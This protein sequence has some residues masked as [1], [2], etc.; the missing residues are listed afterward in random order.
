MKS[1]YRIAELSFGYPHWNVSYEFSMGNSHFSVERFAACFST[2]L[3]IN[4][5][6]A[7]SSAV[8][9]IS[10]VGFPT[11]I[12]IGHKS[13]LHPINI[14]INSYSPDLP[15]SDG[16]VLTHALL[17][18]SI[19]ERIE[20]GD[21]K[22][23]ASFFF[24]SAIF[25][26][27]MLDILKS[28]SK[29][30][31]HYYGDPFLL[32]E[33]PLC[34]RE[35]LLSQFGLKST[36]FFAYFTNIK[37][38]FL[39]TKDRPLFEKIMS[40][41]FDRIINKCD[42]I[43]GSHEYLYHFNQRRNFIQRKRFLLSD[44]HPEFEKQLRENQVAEII[45]L[46]PSKFQLSPYM[47]Y[48]TINAA[49]MLRHNKA[50]GFSVEELESILNLNKED[51][52]KTRAYQLKGRNMDSLYIKT[53]KKIFSRKAKYDF[54]F[55]VHPLEFKDVLKG[56]FIIRILS[57]IMPMNFLETAL[58][59]LPGYLLGTIENIT[60]LHT[61]KQANGLIYCLVITPQMFKKMN[62]KLIYKKV[63]R[64][65]DKANARGVKIIGLGA[66]VK[67]VGDAG[68]TINELSSLPVT[69][70]NS[71]TVGAT[72][73]SLEQAVKKMQLVTYDTKQNIYDG[74]AMIIG[75]TGSI[76]AACSKMLSKSY[77]RVCLVSTRLENLNNLANEIQKIS[78]ACE[79]AF[80]TDSNKFAAVSDVIVIATS[81]FDQKVIDIKKV[82]SGCVIAD[83]SA[84]ANISKEEILKRPDILVMKSGELLLPKDYD[85]NCYL[86]LPP[87][88]LYACLVETAVLAME[89]R[90]EAFTK[91]RAIDF[92]KV[93]EIIEI[94]KK[95]GV[96]LAP[97]R[98]LFGFI[99]DSEV[100][101]IKEK[102]NTCSSG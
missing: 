81:A 40:P 90:Y 55:I 56:P 64:I 47:S 32:N 53:T 86:G 28:Y 38:N 60:S 31:R 19:R 9:A 13:Y 43:C 63:L 89:N 49:L 11:I 92:N 48:S 74:T 4:R 82:K 58:S 70:G 15:I 75:A 1:F 33:F 97:M 67:I 10:L 44:S 78:P 62:P 50:D 3:L 51:V 5:M 35:G 59:Y 71:L 42:Y 84:P 41:L 7:L 26:P 91:G 76:G 30:G 18:Q 16:G 66:Y 85:V 20:K 87:K 88:L 77:K 94:S 65:I 52:F 68:L 93:N 34:F 69:T 39:N 99:Y 95:H 17:A 102:A 73:W 21:I 6:Q 46:F 25:N 96:H 83:C 14:K 29:T 37:D 101:L 98:S 23:N 24:P 80:S 61:Q 2:H 22:P 36:L 12:R 72:L 54:A 27:A 100:E 79:V 45:N 57:K 8:D